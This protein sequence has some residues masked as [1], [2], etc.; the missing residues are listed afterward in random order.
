MSAGAP[1]KQASNRPAA[2]DGWAPAPAPNDLSERARI[3]L[4]LGGEGV[5]VAL[6][7]ACLLL[8]DR[9]SPLLARNELSTGDRNA[10]LFWLVLGGLLPLALLAL[11]AYRN[12]DA[13]FGA[14]RVVSRLALPAIPLAAYPALFCTDVWFKQ[15]L[16]Y[17]ILLAGF[18]LLLDRCLSSA[19]AIVPT[20]FAGLRAPWAASPAKQRRLAVLLVVFAAAAYTAYT[21]YLT[22]LNHY[23][24]GTGAYDLAIYDNLM[25][26]ALKGE[27]YRSTVLFGNRGGNSLSTHSEYGMVL[28]LPFYALHPGAEAMLSLQAV[29]FG[30]AAV[31]LYFFAAS[32]LGQWKA[33]VVALAYLLYAPLHGAQF[34]DF[35]WLPVTT[36]FHFLLY[37][38]IAR[39]RTWPLLF[40]VLVL[41]SLRED[42]AP[43]LALLGLYLLLNGPRVRLGL[44][45]S[46]VSCV[47]FVVNKF[48]IMPA[49]G[50]WW[51][52]QL[53]KDL[54]GPGEKGWGSILRTIAINP[55]YVMTTTFTQA[56]LEYALH[57]FAPL[58]FLPL[59]RARLLWFALP[60]FLF[61]IMTTGYGATTS[62]AFQY[63][64]HWIA[65]L[66]AGM[67]VVLRVLDQQGKRRSAAALIAM[68]AALL[69]HSAV[70]GVVLVPTSFVGGIKPIA[71]SLT[72]AE[73]QRYGDLRSLIAKIPPDASVTATDFE[74][75]HVSNR[76]DVY[77]IGQDDSAGE[78]L[79]VDPERYR[80]AATRQHVHKLL[81]ERPYGL[82]AK[83]ENRIFLFRQ[84]HQSPDTDAAVR[85]LL[86]R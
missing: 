29:V 1:L 69:S 20:G 16:N 8:G 64:S 57:L 77:A 23:R 68:C 15:P 85:Y 59:R 56:K 51:F 35:H 45:L 14:A 67:I 24:F 48:V 60:G 27:P 54:V 7:V 61:T 65:Y 81:R 44:L 22:I 50:T 76:K 62:I 2:V 47:W 78:Y 40:S 17:L 10:M 11:R 34:Y 63:T 73:R 74:A 21:G 12:A 79:L 52:D 66:F 75:P 5:A 46:V 82:V 53:Y 49:L 13:A 55:L 83:V 9:L 6:G 33:V 28:F 37:W 58:A 25:F 4:L 31:P 71:F 36:L 30:F 41:F 38:S 26:N 43:G 42:V 3:V 19:L 72:D 39:D 84:G 86:E 80:L 32:Q 70:F 18:V